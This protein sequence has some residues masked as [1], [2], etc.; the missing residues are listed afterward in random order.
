MI[1]T[2]GFMIGFYIIVRAIEM[3]CKDY[4]GLAA[5]IVMGIAAVILI[6]VTIISMSDLYTAAQ[7]SSHSLSNIP[8]F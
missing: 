3:F 1:P 7:S 5:K 6:I 2:I 8:N 4:K